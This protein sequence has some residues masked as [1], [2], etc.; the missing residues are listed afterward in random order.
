MNS[1]I[2][3][4]MCGFRRNLNCH[5]VIRQLNDMIEGQKTDY[6]SSADIKRFFDNLNYGWC[7]GLMR[8]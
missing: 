6:I 4:N 1:Y 5:G 7:D 8:R 2:Y 3:N